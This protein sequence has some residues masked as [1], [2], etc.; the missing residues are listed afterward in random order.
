[1][2]SEYKLR[3]NGPRG[4]ILN[5]PSEFLKI[6]DFRAGDKVTL[7]ILESGNLLVSKKYDRGKR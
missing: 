5:I 7:T 3:R 6:N 1:M 4:V 2:K